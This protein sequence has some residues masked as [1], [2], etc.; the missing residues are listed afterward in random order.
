M[1]ITSIR[2]AGDVD[3]PLKSRAKKLNRSKNCDISQ[4]VIEFFAR[5][6]LEDSRWQDTL[7]TLEPIKTGKSSGEAD[8]NA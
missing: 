1:G 4:S 2:I 8:V 3:K 7:K 5:Q 6:L